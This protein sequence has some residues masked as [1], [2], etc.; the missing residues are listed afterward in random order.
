MNLVTKTTD[1]PNRLW[2]VILLMF[3]IW[4][5]YSMIHNGRFFYEMFSS[6]EDRKFFEEWFGK[7]LHFPFPLFMAFLAKGGEF[8]GGIMVLF[9]L[10][11]RVGASLI[12]TVMLVATLTANIGKNWEVDGTITVSYFLFAIALIY[13]G[14]GKYALDSL[15]KANR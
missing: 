4:L 12:A 1:K 15:F 9:G 5:G 7:G 11:T 10:F 3:H 14:G 8:L 2:D 13:W 6:A